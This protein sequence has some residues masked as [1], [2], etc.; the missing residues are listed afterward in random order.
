MRVCHYCE[1]AQPNNLETNQQPT[2]TSNISPATITKNK[3]LDA[4]FPFKLEELSTMS[5]FSG[6]ALKEKP[7]MAIY[8]DVKVDGH[9]IK[10]ILDNE[11]AVNHAASTRI[12]TTNRA[13]KTPI[14]EIDNFSIKVNATQYQALVG[15]NWLSKTNVLF[16]WNMQELQ[17][18][19]N[20]Q[21]TCIPAMCGHFK[22][23]NLT[24]PLIKFEKEKKKPIWE[25]YQVS[26][27]NT[28]HNELPPVSLWNDNSKESRAKNLLRKPTK[29]KERGRKKNQQPT[30]IPLII[31]TLHLTNPLIAKLLSMGAC[32]GDNKEYTSET[33][34]YCHPCIIEHFGRPKWVG[35]WDNKPCL[36]C[37]KTFLDER[38]KDELCIDTI[39][40]SNWV[41]KGTPIDTA[42]RRAVKYLN[43]LTPEKI[44]TIKNN[45]SESIEL[46]WDPEPVINF[47]DPEQFHKHY[48]E[49]A[50]TREEQKQC[51]EE[52]NT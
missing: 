8:T 35:K 39:L 18:S 51:L 24:T 21:H 52:I 48:Q 31:L 28:K 20:S 9:F 38:I 37:E 26:W 5:L 17:I 4:I 16:D 47:L 14:G 12:I 36:A 41:R 7:I 25:V 34:F 2:L 30:A 29:E 33:K 27:A 42:W 23:T 3:S 45:P 50:P 10:L 6:A 49:L 22:T 15:N 19:Q 40:I 46:D 11:S 44:K 43:R 32:C 1:D 13:T